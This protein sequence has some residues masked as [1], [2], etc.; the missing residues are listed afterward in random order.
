MAVLPKEAEELLSDS[1]IDE[2]AELLQQIEENPAFL[3]FLKETNPV[4]LNHFNST[5]GRLHA[6][7]ARK[8]WRSRDGQPGSARPEQLIPGTPGSASERGDWRVWLLMA[9]RGSG[10]SFA[11]AQAIRELCERDWVTPRPSIALVSTTLEAVRT[12]MIEQY[13]EPIL[14]P[15]IRKYNRADLEIFLKNGVHLKGYS[16]ERPNRL[17]GPNFVAAW[18]DEV[19]ALLDADKAPSE[20]STWSN[21]EFATR[22]DDDG[23]WEPRIIATTTPKPVRLLRV[24][25]RQDDYWPGLV[26]D[27]DVVITHMRTYDN[28]DNLAGGFRRRIISRYEGTR[29]AEQELDGRLLDE[30]EGAL[31]SQGTINRMRRSFD[32]L[33]GRVGGYHRVVVSVDPT[34]GDGSVSNDECGIIVGCMGN[35]NKVWILDDRSI[36]GPPSAWCRAIGEAY[37]YWGASYALAEINQGGTLVREA[38]GRY[39]ENIPVKTVRA[40]DGKYVRAEGPALLCEQDEVRFAGRFPILSDQLTTWD[41]IEKRDESP[42]RL[43]AF[44]QLIH[45]LKPARAVSSGSTGRLYR[46]ARGRRRQA[47]RSV[48]RRN[49]TRDPRVRGNMAPINKD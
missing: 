28:L 8:L 13:L 17:R 12:D 26:D 40:F 1:A 2:W 39:Y 46:G 43:D 31:W 25:D 19:A 44:V 15:M 29:L 4:L 16:S 33:R 20:D 7:A 42:D 36:K 9:G 37:T 3:H 41:P 11:A 48:R 6:E 18:V 35:D 45:H 5:M 49:P 21:L 27:P 38:L 30:V 23:T 32:E 24:I 47:R 34:I 14:G 22:A 10:K